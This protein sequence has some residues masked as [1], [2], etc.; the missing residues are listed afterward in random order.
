MW[1]FWGNIEKCINFASVF[2]K[3]VKNLKSHTLK[4]VP[5]FSNTHY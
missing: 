5:G 4:I 3:V 1:V 2:F